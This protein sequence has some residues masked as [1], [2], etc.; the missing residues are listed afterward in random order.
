MTRAK[1]WLRV[2]GVGPA[3]KRL[4]KEIALAKANSPCLRFRYPSAADLETMKRD[5]GRQ[6]ALS[7][8]QERLLDEI[9]D[10]QLG[11]YW[12]RRRKPTKKK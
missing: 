2:T 8:E 4:A 5:L 1:V 3:A 12:R 7:Q 6:A 9:P 10:E 11:E